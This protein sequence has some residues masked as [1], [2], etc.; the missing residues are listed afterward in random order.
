[1]PMLKCNKCNLSARRCSMRMVV[2]VSVVLN[3]LLSGILVGIIAGS[4]TAGIASVV[5]VGLVLAAAVYLAR[6]RGVLGKSVADRTRSRSDK[7]G[8]PPAYP[9]SN[10]DG[11]GFGGG[12]G[13]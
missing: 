9:G 6:E 2:L 3:V 7:D 10:I 5:L 13:G 4:I 1:L 11:G 12:Y 8:V